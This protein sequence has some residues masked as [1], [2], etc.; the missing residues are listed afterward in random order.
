MYFFVQLIYI[1]LCSYYA[2]YLDIFKLQISSE[3]FLT[4]AAPYPSRQNQVNEEGKNININ[5]NKESFL[6][7]SC[8]QIKFIPLANLY[9][10][11]D[12]K[13]LAKNGK[14]N[15]YIPNKCI[16]STISIIHAMNTT[17]FSLKLFTRRSLFII[18]STFIKTVSQ[19]KKMLK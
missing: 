12:R 16:F 3:Q 17:D 11:L 10:N 18:V 14:M 7:H 8:M 5:R 9:P 6:N 19:E 15:T 2:I 4:P 1:Y 13:Y